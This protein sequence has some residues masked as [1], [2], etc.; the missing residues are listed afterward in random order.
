MSHSKVEFY[1]FKRY[2]IGVLFLSEDEQE[3]IETH[4]DS[5]TK[6]THYNNHL[7]SPQKRIVFFHHKDILGLTSYKFKGVFAYDSVKSSPTVGSI[8]KKIEDEL[9]IK[10]TD[11]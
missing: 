11:L 8:W 2:S 5:D 10:L 6:A 4:S 3:I 7:N 9:K 1:L